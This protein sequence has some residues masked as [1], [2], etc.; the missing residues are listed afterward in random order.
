LRQEGIGD[1]RLAIRAARFVSEADLPRGA[2]GEQLTPEEIWRN[3][4][5]RES[6]DRAIRI[7]LRSPSFLFNGLV[8]PRIP[9]KSSKFL[10]SLFSIPT[11]LECM[12]TGCSDRPSTFG[13]FSSRAIEVFFFRC[14]LRPFAPRAILGGGLLIRPR[15][16]RRARVLL[17]FEWRRLREQQVILQG[18]DAQT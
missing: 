5:K 7:S 8:F 14:V 16:F 10:P 13:I 15:R 3:R 11:A 6:F 1:D 4:E 12:K 17:R 9:R 2:V 18:E